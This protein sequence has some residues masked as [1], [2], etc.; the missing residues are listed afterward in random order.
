VLRTPAAALDPKACKEA[1]RTM[2][3]SSQTSTAELLPTATPGRTS[4]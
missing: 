1:K 2:G 3:E 4:S